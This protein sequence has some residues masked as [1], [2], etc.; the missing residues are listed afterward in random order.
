VRLSA[1]FLFLGAAACTPAVPRAPSIAPTPRGSSTWS[2][3]PGDVI[4]LKNWGAPEQSGDLLVHERGTVLVPT[5]GNVAV[6]GLSPDSLE[7]RMVRAFSGRVDASRV[8]VQLQR[9]ITVTGGV[10]APS[11][12][13]VDGSTSVLSV[14][15]RS[16][17]AIRPGGDN[18]VF[19]VR[20]GEASREV[21]VAD[22]MADI[23]VRASDQLYVQD[24]PFAVRNALALRAM[25]E[26]VQVT[27]T[28]VTIFVLIRQN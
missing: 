17:G 27:A 22:H 23:G 28:L 8:D 20:T 6:Q 7:Q 9:A 13:L 19:V 24:P 26:I 21:S 15:A 5:V 2:V 10:K 18:R 25:Y 11:V 12:Q 4:R 3:E 16:G 14:M 1:L